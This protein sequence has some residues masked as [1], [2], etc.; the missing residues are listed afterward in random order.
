M[1]ATEP[2]AAGA[3]PAQR[4][5]VRA[6]TVARRRGHITSGLRGVPEAP[7]SA[8]ASRSDPRVPAVLSA[9]AGR[10]VEGQDPRGVATMAPGQVRPR[11]QPGHRERQRR[12]R[13]RDG[14]RGTMSERHAREGKPIVEK[15]GGV[16]R[17]MLSIVVPG[18][19]LW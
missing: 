4:A 13:G 14:H 19:L 6:D 15:K 11:A 9:F 1:G 5:H 17:S 8:V 2:A 12:G 18:L 7:R 10:L 16:G 3:G